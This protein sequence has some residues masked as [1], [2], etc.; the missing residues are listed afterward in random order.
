MTVSYKAFITYSH[1]DSAFAA[2]LQK[3]L[4]SYSVPSR[5]V[6]QETAIGKVP[7]RL[8]P[9]FRD[10]EELSAGSNLSETINTALRNSEFLICVCSPA[11]RASQW[12]N[13][14]ISEFRRLHGDERIICVIVDGEPYA[15]SRPDEEGRECFP[16]ALGLK[17]TKTGEVTLSSFEHVAADMRPNADGRK[18]ATMKI[19]AGLIGVRLDQLVQRDA[20]QRARVWAGV[21]AASLVLAVAMVG[22]AV[23]AVDAQKEAELR[24]GQAENLIGFMLGDLRKRLQPIGRLDVLDAVGDE[25]MQYFEALDENATSQDLLSRAMA[26]RQI[27]EVRFNQ[28]QLEP[29]LV[30]FSESRSVLRRLFDNDSRV[31]DYLFELGQSEFWVGYVHY[32]RAEYDEALSA[33][34]GYMEISRDLLDRQPDNQDYLAELA[35]AWSNLGSVAR[36]RGDK[37]AAI[38]Y[39]RESVAVNERQLEA[40]PGD[41]GL[42]T[43]LAG[44]YSW[45]GTAE[46]ELGDLDASEAAFRIALQQFDELAQSEENARYLE[47]RAATAALLSNLLLL[48]DKIDESYTLSGFA[49]DQFAELLERDP[50][51]NRWKRQFANAAKDFAERLHLLGDHAAADSRLAES[52]RHFDELI[53]VDPSNKEWQEARQSLLALEA[54]IRQLP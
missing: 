22:L 50:A 11:A 34:N 27:G 7:S 46:Q 3:K 42:M 21:A 9:I 12:V 49:Y 51:N 37:A 54:R 6:D 17:D 18:S 24:R 23:Y 13:Q 38:N 39:F 1:E 31:D 5:L 53:A 16:A 43:D 52:R 44:G 48:Q 33:M 28:G 47:R 2:W 40:K 25:A 26:L 15:S 20:Q 14:E 45:I 36:S 19:I 4:E 29:A 32:E 35:Y 8:R 10:R 41:P 30:A